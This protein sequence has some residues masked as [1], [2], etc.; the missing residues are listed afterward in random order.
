MMFA[1]FYVASLVGGP[2]T[3]FHQLEDM[4]PEH[5]VL[6]PGKWMAWTAMFVIT[7]VGS[8]MGPQLW[9]RFYS[10]KSHNTFNMMP[11]LLAFAA[12][13]YTGSM[14]HIFKKDCSLL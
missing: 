3:M 14:L 10:V 6:A 8:F 5:T 7:P 9:A 12:I 13:A 2:S 1:G 4:F 11:F